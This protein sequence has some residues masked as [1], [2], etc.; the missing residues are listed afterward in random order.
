M[1]DNT[2][3]LC[4][5]WKTT[6][7]PFLFIPKLNF[8]FHPKSTSL[9]LIRLMFMWTIRESCRFTEKNFSHYCFSFLLHPVPMDVGWRAIRAPTDTFL[10]LFRV[11]CNIILHVSKYN[12]WMNFSRVF[13]EYLL[14]CYTI[15]TYGRI[16]SVGSE[17]MRPVS[18]TLIS[19]IS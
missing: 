5:H 13:I 10:V 12:H 17:W 11:G 18:W 1:G 7:K 16:W 19:P 9:N 8:S 14:Q 15:L 3:N 2:R 6:S 4:N